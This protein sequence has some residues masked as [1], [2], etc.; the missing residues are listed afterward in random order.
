MR[1][2]H[3]LDY[4]LLSRSAQYSDMRQEALKLHIMGK[5]IKEISEY[6]NVHRSSV[7]KWLKSGKS[8]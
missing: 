1:I 4:L 2:K 6:L 3:I 5:S 8:S 7:S